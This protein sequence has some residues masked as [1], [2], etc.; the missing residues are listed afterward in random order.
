MDF[1]CD[2]SEGLSSVLS[3]PFPSCD[4]GL[5][6]PHNSIPFTF[7]LEFHVDDEPNWFVMPFAHHTGFEGRNLPCLL[8]AASL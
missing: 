2:D 1:R 6:V 5:K 3:A 4:F 7:V 8:A